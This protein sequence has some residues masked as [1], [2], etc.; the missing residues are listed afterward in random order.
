MK[1]GRIIVKLKKLR[2]KEI[3]KATNKAYVLQRVVHW[4]DRRLL[5]T[6]HGIQNTEGVIG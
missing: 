5:N 1:A 2:E 3:L 6:K 4:T